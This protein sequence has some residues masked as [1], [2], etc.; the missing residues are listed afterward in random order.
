MAD[1]QRKLKEGSC[2]KL[3]IRAAQL[4]LIMIMTIWMSGCLM[5]ASDLVKFPGR[6]TGWM[7]I[8]ENRTGYNTTVIKKDRYCTIHGEIS[9]NKL[10]WGDYKMIV[11]GEAYLLLGG[12]L[13]GEVVIT[14]VTN[15]TDTLRTDGEWGGKF[16]QEV[17][18]GWGSWFAL[19]NGN[20][21]VD[22]KWMAQKESS[23][24]ATLNLLGY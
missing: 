3:L 20:F 19:P 23:I 15:G 14:L 7:G 21:S 1:S 2:P 11:D 24:D 12:D 16:D 8:G 10:G 4:F 22:G 13:I 17:P 5:E 6:W 9:G 18:V